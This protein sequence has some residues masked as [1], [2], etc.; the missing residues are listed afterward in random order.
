MV[1]VEVM[2]ADYI[3]YSTER[4]SHV[5]LIEENEMLEFVGMKWYE[6]R[7]W[8]DTTGNLIN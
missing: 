8:H 6:T 7:H 1:L 2:S 5:D 4:S 3:F